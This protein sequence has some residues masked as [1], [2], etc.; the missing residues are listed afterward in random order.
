MKI[1]RHSRYRRL[2]I[3]PRGK[4]GERRG[5][6]GSNYKRSSYFTDL[7]LRDSHIRWYRIS[8]SG[9]LW[10]EKKKNEQYRSIIQSYKRSFQSLQTGFK[11]KVQNTFFFFFFRDRY[12]YR[13]YLQWE[14][15]EQWYCRKR[16]NLIESLRSISWRISIWTLS[17]CEMTRRK[18][19]NNP[20]VE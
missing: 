14:L 16:R 5:I 12:W 1:G 9:G 10:R 15:R 3:Y 11:E 13:V 6:E 4:E 20:W 8:S 17:L 18:R 2:K 19:V 7:R